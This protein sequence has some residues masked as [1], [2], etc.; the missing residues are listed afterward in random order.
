MAIM[1]AA[2]VPMMAGTASAQTSEYYRNGR[3][4]SARSERQVYYEPQSNYTYQQPSTYDKHRKAINVGV[5]A[6]AGAIIGAL[7]GGK[8][9]ALIGGAA[10]VVGGLIAT[11]VQ[12]PRNPNNNTYSYNY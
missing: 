4:H 6:G 9:G 2:A 7:L 3:R 11:K 8:K 10:G 5:A 1:L 12:K